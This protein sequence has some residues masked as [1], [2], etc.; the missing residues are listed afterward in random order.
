MI[1]DLVIEIKEVVEEE[2]TLWWAEIKNPILKGCRSHGYT[3]ESA[4]R[5]VQVMALQILAEQVQRKEI[6]FIENIKFTIAPPEAK[7]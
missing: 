6:I 5:S 4:R 2:I 7:K 1:I 3:Y